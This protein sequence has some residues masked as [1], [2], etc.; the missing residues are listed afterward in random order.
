VKKQFFVLLIFLT[1]LIKA[2]NYD[3]LAE[4]IAQFSTMSV[5]FGVG[6][7]LQRAFARLKGKPLSEWPAEAKEE[8]HKIAKKLDTLPSSAKESL[9][10]MSPEEFKNFLKEQADKISDA[11][12]E[13][14]IDVTPGEALARMSPNMR[15]A[16][17]DPNLDMKLTTIS[18]NYEIMDAFRVKYAEG[19][20][21]GVKSAVQALLKKAHENGIKNLQELQE[22]TQLFSEEQAQS[23]EEAMRNFGNP[24]INEDGSLFG[25][26]AG[27]LEDH[28]ADMMPE[29]IGE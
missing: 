13:H 26:G 9:R 28:M 18:N 16:L 21:A 1:F 4:L 22:N 24:E 2:V 25:E 23:L 10:K 8:L 11:L 20:E 29:V 14:Q 15:T 6:H 19:G 3:E 7:N 17:I 12:V 27:E 5:G